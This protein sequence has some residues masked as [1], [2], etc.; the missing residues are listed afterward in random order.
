ML[1]LA[2]Q[3]Y[4]DSANGHDSLAEA[5]EADGAAAP[6]IAHYRRALELDPGNAHAVARLQGLE[7]QGMKDD[8]R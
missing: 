3:L 6:A 4:P 1:G 7:Q 5:Y 2:V 8:A